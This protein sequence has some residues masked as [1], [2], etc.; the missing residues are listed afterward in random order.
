[1]STA[2]TPRGSWGGFF[3]LVRFSRFLVRV[4]VMPVAVA[5]VATPSERHS[6]AN[7]SKRRRPQLAELVAEMSCRVA[8]GYVDAAHNHYP[9]DQSHHWNRV[10]HY[11]RGGTVNDDQIELLRQPEE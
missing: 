4:R 11:G 2:L 10:R 3:E 7:H 6:I 9:A 5:I 1:M 8:R